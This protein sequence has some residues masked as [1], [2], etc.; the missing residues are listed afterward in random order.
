MQ[1]QLMMITMIAVL[2]SGC[3]TYKAG[4]THAM[5]PSQYG[6]YVVADNGV[7][8]AA[9]LYTG[10]AKV[11]SGFYIDVNSEGYYPIQVIL[12][13]GSDSRILLPKESVRIVD[14]NGHEYRPVPGAVMADEFEK[15]KMAYA[16]LGFGIFSY[17][18]ADDANQKMRADW[19]GKE[20][21]PDTLIDAGRSDSGFAYFKMP[22]GVK[23]NGM[24]L[25]LEV[26]ALE[27]STRTPIELLLR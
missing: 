16:L 1:K 17:M 11:K 24:K 21:G 27:T 2:A 13:N 23:P 12:R 4:V 7:E 18:S 9:D 19:L 3:A 5:S 25:Q 8:A 6:N 22:K 14:S 26:E 20:L 10:E 15:N